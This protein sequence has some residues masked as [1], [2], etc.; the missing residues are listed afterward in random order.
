MLTLLRKEINSFFSSL[1]GYLAIITFLLANGLFLWVFPGDMN[2]LN[3]GY[4]DIAPLFDLAPW[5]FLFL[6][7]AV[8]MRLFAEEKRTGTIELLYTRPLSELQIVLGKYLAGLSLV[9]LSL[10]PTLIYFY[11]AYDLGIAKESITDSS[12][13]GIFTGNLSGN[14]DVGATWGSFIG[15]FFLS[16]IYV[17]IGVFA[18]AISESQIAA[19]I[20]AVVLS[21]AFYLGFEALAMLEIWGN[22]ADWVENIGINAHYMSMSRGVIDSRDLLYFL[23]VIGFIIYLTQLLLQRG[24]RN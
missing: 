6:V 8:T 10:L 22:G 20:L 23:S 24:Q 14:M 13:W 5:V 19:F 7:P 3:N 11:S 15:L 4:S 21:F 18:S 1:I 2:I 17:A 12:F 16:A 9:L